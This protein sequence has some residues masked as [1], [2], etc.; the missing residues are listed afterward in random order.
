MYQM[1]D[2]DDDD[3][4]GDDGAMD[5]IGLEMEMRNKKH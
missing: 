3:D 1:D 4:D 2:D 5:T